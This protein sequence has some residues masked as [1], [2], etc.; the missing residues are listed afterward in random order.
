MP[1]YPPALTKE[2]MLDLIEMAG[3]EVCLKQKTNAKQVTLCLRKDGKD[4]VAGWF[5]LGTPEN[6]LIQRAFECFVWKQKQC[7]TIRPL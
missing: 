1:Y 7:H 5:N 6:E 2:Q 3:Y 4:L